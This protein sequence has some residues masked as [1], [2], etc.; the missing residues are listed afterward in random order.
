MKLKL[1]IVLLALPLVTACP[2]KTSDPQ[3]V[4]VAPTTS[5]PPVASEAG[6]AT[7]SATATA[8]ATAT[9]TPTPTS[10]AAIDASMT[11]RIKSKFGPQCRFERACGNLWGIDCDAAV[12]GPYYY[13]KAGTLEQVSVCGGACMG[14]RCTNCPP[15]EWTC[16]TY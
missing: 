14:G 16:A 8:T 11:A 15:K 12:D 9:P 4:V 3:T 2:Q 7:P 5:A 10:S 6:A 1:S 13:A